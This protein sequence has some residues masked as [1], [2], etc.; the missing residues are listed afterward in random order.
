LHIPSTCLAYNTSV[1]NSTGFTPSFLEFG[2]E[3][4]L[5]SDLHQPDSSLPLPQHH[6]DYA[7]QLKSRLMQAFQ[8]ARETLK[9]SQRSQKGYYDCWAQAKAYQVGDR[10]LWLDKQTRR[11]RCM[12]LNRPWTGPWKVI[13]RLNGVV[14]RIKHCGAAGSY[15]WVKRRVLHFNQLKPFNGMKAGLWVIQ[16]LLESRFLLR[17]GWSWSNHPGR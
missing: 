5:P 8:S 1:H 9:V 2:R 11:G 10:V 15:S 6:S 12:E 4:C 7:S 16:Y 13:K 14:Y 17:Q 3:L